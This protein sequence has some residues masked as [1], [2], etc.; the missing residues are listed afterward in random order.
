VA[1]L[2]WDK[3]QAQNLGRRRGTD[4]VG[5]TSGMTFGPPSKANQ[6]YVPKKPKH[7]PKPRTAEQARQWMLANTDLGNPAPQK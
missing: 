4:D 1:K 7:Q 5:K 3:V 2:N 6:P